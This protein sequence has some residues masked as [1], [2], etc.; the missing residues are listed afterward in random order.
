MSRESAINRQV[1]ERQA[2]AYDRQRDRRLTERKWL[3]RCVADVT[4][5]GAVL[6]L[7]CGTGRPIAE[8]LVAQGYCV[9]GVDFSPA[10]LGLFRTHLP[11]ALAVAAD[12]RR[13]DLG[14]RFAAIVGWGSFFHLMEAEQRR[15]LPRI[16][17][18]LAPGGRLLL[19]V[20]PAEGRVTGHVGGEQVHHA[21]L[22]VAEYRDLLARQG[23]A[24]EDFV[25]EDPDCG[26]HTLL[27][28][29]RRAG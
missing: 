26:G 5:G 13:L 11:Q 23:C 20:G 28:A 3:A 24:V 29:R 18:H 7:G 9:T 15:A 14:C 8:W 6:D 19:T 12:M 16:A 22:S 10:M 2:R 1:Y 4:P 21:S 25:P 27:L 17:G